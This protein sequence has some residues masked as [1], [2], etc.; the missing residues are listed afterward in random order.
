[1]SI[2]ESG[3][4]RQA[5]SDFSAVVDREASSSPECI[6]DNAVSLGIF[7]L[8]W[9][10]WQKDLKQIEGLTGTPV[11]VLQFLQVALSDGAPYRYLGDTPWHYGKVT[12]GSLYK[13]LGVTGLYFTSGYSQSELA[14]IFGVERQDIHQNINRLLTGLWEYALP[15][16]QERFPQRLI[17]SRKKKSHC[18]NVS[19]YIRMLGV[20]RA[21]EQ[22]ENYYTASKTYGLTP[23]QRESLPYWVHSDG[24]KKMNHSQVREK[25]QQ[26]MLN[27]VK[28]A[29]DC[30]SRKAAMAKIPRVLYLKKSTGDNPDFIALS[31][32]GV[33]SRWVAKS[34]RI[35]EERGIS[36][37]GYD[38]V[39]NLKK[40]QKPLVHRYRYIWRDDVPAAIRILQ[41]HGLLSKFSHASIHT[42]QEKV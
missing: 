12:A 40:R 42:L 33:N 1:M 37:G 31:A 3:Q 23:A 25:E 24:G 26:D 21:V 9:L 17:T 2:V 13:N 32:L 28:T 5:F 14:R 6:H 30:V 15:V 7:C 11:T 29:S 34:I 4:Y 18:S 39:I 22:G 36:V 10:R 38:R 19:S 35:I 41:E 8:G 20:I 27:A 16:T